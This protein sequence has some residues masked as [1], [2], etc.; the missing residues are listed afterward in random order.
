MGKKTINIIKWLAL[1]PAISAVVIFISIFAISVLE[2]IIEFSPLAKYSSKESSEFMVAILCG[3]ATAAVTHLLNPKPY[4]AAKILVFLAMSLVIM[5]NLYLD[6]FFL[7][8]EPD[9]LLN[10]AFLISG[11]VT[12]LFLSKTARKSKDIEKTI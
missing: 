5:R 9:I 8:R 12:F 10:A 4:K 7:G 11:L 1:L 3:S 2:A 6:L